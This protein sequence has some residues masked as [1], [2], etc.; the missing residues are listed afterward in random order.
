MSRWASEQCQQWVE[1]CHKRTVRNRPDRTDLFLRAGF[2]FGLRARSVVNNFGAAHV[3]ASQ[4]EIAF[5]DLR[6]RRATEPKVF[7]ILIPKRLLH[8]GVLLRIKLI[9]VGLRFVL[10]ATGLS[11]SRLEL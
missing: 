9:V 1:R 11:H 8:R 7:P 2:A 6:G 3:D 5:M 10:H 4:E